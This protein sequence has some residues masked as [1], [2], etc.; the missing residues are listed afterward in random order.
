MNRL[1][2]GTS[3]LQWSVLAVAVVGLQVALASGAAAQVD[4]PPFAFDGGP[5]AGSVGIAVTFNGLGSFDADGDALAFAWDFGDGTVGS[6]ATVTH[7]YTTTA[8]YVV[9]LTVTA[10][11]L[12]TSDETVAVIGNVLGARVFALQQ[13]VG[14]LSNAKPA[15]VRI[16][17]NGNF[18][19]SAVNPAEVWMRSVGSGE[20]IRAIPASVVI[21]GD[22]DRNGA[23]ELKASFAKTDL[24]RLLSG[25]GA[26]SRVR[27]EG[28]LRGGAWFAAELDLPVSGGAIAAQAGLFNDPIAGIATLEL[29]AASTTGARVEVFDVTGRV[30]RTLSGT[31]R[32]DLASAVRDG[33]GTGTGIYFYRATDAEGTRTGRFVLL[34]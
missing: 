6:G 19:L 1:V 4:E 34:R 25:T 29:A 3:L 22:R 32:F 20:A 5:Y 9:K 18:G 2:L 15:T 12:T 7:V 28:Q 8:T 16:E 14:K 10:N 11:G 21:D 13:E 31:G 17:T 24:R 33:G 30:L 23:T 26:G 27:I